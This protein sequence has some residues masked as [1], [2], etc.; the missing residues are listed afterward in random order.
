M[1]DMQRQAIDVFHDEV[2]AVVVLGQQAHVED[3]HEVPAAAAASPRGSSLASSRAS[4]RASPK[5]CGAVS[6]VR[7]VCRDTLTATGRMNSR[8]KNCSR[9]EDGAE[10][11]AGLHLQQAILARQHLAEDALLEGGLLHD[12]HHR[13]ARN[14]LP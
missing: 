13:E 5:R 4:T 1:W 10:G 2:G 7:P 6:S 3:L 9:A 8:Q 11:A 14:P 12:R